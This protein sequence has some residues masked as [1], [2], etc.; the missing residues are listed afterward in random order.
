[1][2]LP[3]TTGLSIALMNSLD[4]YRANG[5][6]LIAGYQFSEDVELALRQ[7]LSTTVDD[8]VSAIAKNPRPAPTVAPVVGLPIP[9]T[10]PQNQEVFGFE[11]PAE[12]QTSFG[13][14]NA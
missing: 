8:L 10:T 1:M 2:L 9:Q 13:A 4:R 14:F 5:V 12:V 7:E 6:E 3:I 11:V